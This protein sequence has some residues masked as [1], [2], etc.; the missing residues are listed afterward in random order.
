MK[1]SLSNVLFAL[2]TLMVLA[3]GQLG[4]ANASSVEVTFRYD[5]PTNAPDIESITVPGSFNGWDPHA[6]PMEA[7]ADD[8]WQVTLELELGEH[9]Y[10]F[11]INDSWPQ[12]MCHDVTWGDPEAAR[13]IDPEADDCEGDGFGGQNAVRTL[14]APEPDPTHTFSYTPPPD[15]PTIQ[16]IA[17][18]GSFNG[19]DAS[20]SPMQRQMDGSWQ[21]TVE[22]EPGRHEYKFHF[23]AD[24]PDYDGG[25]WPQDMCE[26]ALWGDPERDL[27]IDPNADGCVDDGHGGQNAYLDAAVSDP[28]RE[29]SGVQHN[30][31]NPAYLSRAAGWLSVRFQ[32]NRDQ[33]NEASLEVAGE[34]YPMHRQLHYRG[35]EVWRVAIPEGSER[36]TLSVDTAEEGEL[37]F[38]PFEVPEDLFEDVPWVAEAIGYQIFPERFWNSNPEFD[39]DARAQAALDTD[40]Y[41]YKAES[42]WRASWGN[43]TPTFTPGWGDSEGRGVTRFHCCHQYFGGD[44]EGVIEKLDHLNSLGVTL[45]Y[46]NPLFTSGSAHSYDTYDYLEIAPNFGDEALLRELID[47]AQARGMRVMWD[48]VPNH[49]GVGHWAFQDAVR[50]GYESDTWAWFRFNVEP[51]EIE[52]GNGEHYG[53]WWGFGSLPELETRN[54]EVMAHLLEVTEH[55]TEFGFDGIRVDVPGDIRNRREF[56]NAFRD[57][58]KTLNPDVYLVG[59]IWQ[60]NPTWLQGDMFDSLMNYAIGQGVIER[61]VTGGLQGRAAAEEMAILYAEYPEAS[62]AMQF[63]LI[64][65]HDTARLL[66]KLGGGGLGDT[67]DEVSLARQRLA[68][69]MLYALPGMPVTFQ[70]DECALLGEGEGPEEKNRYPVQW[71]DCDTEMLEHYQRLAELKH[72]LDALISPVIRSYYGED[73]VLAFYRGEPGD[74]EVLTAFNNAAQRANLDLPE[75][76]WHDAVSGESVRDTLELEPLSWRYLVRR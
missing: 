35:R 5:P 38:G 7:Q 51:G 3:G 59:E 43:L 14:E 74:G 57:T 16:S 26:H 18:P 22:L 24:H 31:D 65:S 6:L 29:G 73:S 27:W 42:A 19:W 9:S 34:V 48:F 67:P 68:A 28:E 15:A 52:V 8:S 4:L 69:A 11:Y 40:S 39:L 23:D 54:P 58:A 70:G 30:P 49:V 60:R 44:L 1:K 41:T 64:S 37:S 53:A 10:K 46:F 2:L 63:N 62:A 20:A 45:I 66:T 32:A 12:D 25:D 36:Y 33:V 76:N 55:W 61:F 72:D 47:E 13:W 75:G 17:V 71:D 56:F 21:V 50:R